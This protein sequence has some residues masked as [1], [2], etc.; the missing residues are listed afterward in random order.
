[1]IRFFI[2]VEK[3]L[4]NGDTMPSLHINILKYRKL[5]LSMRKYA[6]KFTVM[7]LD[8]NSMEMNAAQYANLGKQIQ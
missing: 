1:M 8:C 3:D 6:V 7:E 2:S 5:I 4:T